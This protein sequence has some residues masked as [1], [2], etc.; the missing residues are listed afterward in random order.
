MEFIQII[1]IVIY[2]YLLNE[3]KRIIINFNIITWCGFS[4]KIN[5]NYIIFTN[6]IIVSIKV[7]VILKMLS[8]L[9]ACIGLFI[10]FTIDIRTL[11][12]IIY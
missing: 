1:E 5:L 12:V 11:I 2:F 6:L 8:Y 3:Y 9:I 10:D 7:L 4:Q